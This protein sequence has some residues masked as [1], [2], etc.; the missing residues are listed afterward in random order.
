MVTLTGVAA[1]AHLIRE[2]ARL[3]L[4][5]FPY[6][7]SFISGAD[8]ESCRP[9]SLA[10]ISRALTLSEIVLAKFAYLLSSSV[11]LAHII[12]VSMIIY[13]YFQLKL[14]KVAT[15][16]L[17]TLT[18][19][20]NSLQNE[21]ADNV[22]T[23]VEDVVGDVYVN[24]SNTAPIFEED[25]SAGHVEKA[26]GFRRKV[27]NYKKAVIKRQTSLLLRA[28]KPASAQTT[29][30]APEIKGFLQ[31]KSSGKIFRTSSGF[32]RRYFIA[33]DNVL[34]YY[35]RD[36][37]TTT[38]DLLA[39]IDLDRVDIESPR[40]DTVCLRLEGGSMQLKV[41]SES[42][43]AENARLALEWY[44]SMTNLQWRSQF[45]QGSRMESEDR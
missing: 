28:V 32:Q 38:D 8:V 20:D 35:R 10:F 17:L 6:T 16:D 15:T 9:D 37:R 42:S 13:Q 4:S 44:E 19:T 34:R 5:D 14:D 43:E 23:L 33:S 3:M 2:S 27:G 12:S 30:G 11:L 7:C 41:G 18:S 45:R 36:D 25:G 1:L 39:V 21:G 31:K 26:L 22:T 40:G 29:W 24:E